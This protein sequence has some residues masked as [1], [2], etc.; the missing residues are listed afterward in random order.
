MSTK[1]YLIALLAVSISSCSTAYKSGQTPDD[2]YYSPVRLDGEVR[3]DDK[4]DRREDQVNSDYLEERQIRMQIRNHRWRSFDYDYTYNPYNYGTYHGYYYN[5]FYCPI[6]VYNPGFNTPS[7]PKV[8]TP[9]TINLNTYT[10][11]PTYTNTNVN[12]GPKYG[13]VRNAPVRGYNNSNNSGRL[14]N[15]LNNILNGGRT[16]SNTNSN[17]SSEATPTRSYSETRSSS[18]SSSSGSSSS[19]SSSGTSRPARSGRD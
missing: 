1:L 10:P 3:N 2:V 15:T 17:T 14:S 18:S 8:S 4:E 6:P 9:R 7:N 16:S 13:N 12:S 5:P 11:T 19:G